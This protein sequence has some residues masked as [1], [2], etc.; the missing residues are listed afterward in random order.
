MLCCA[1]LRC[2]CTAVAT[3]LWGGLVPIAPEALILYRTGVDAQPSRFPRT[4]VALGTPPFLLLHPLTNSR[5][6][7]RVTTAAGGPFLVL[8][9][10]LP[11]LSESS[12][13]NNA[14]MTARLQRHRPRYGCLAVRRNRHIRATCSMIPLDARTDMH[15]LCFFVRR[16]NDFAAHNNFSDSALFAP[17]IMRILKNAGKMDGVTFIDQ[18]RASLPGRG[19][20][21]NHNRPFGTRALTPCFR[22]FRG[23]R[24]RI[25]QADT[26][27][28]WLGGVEEWSGGVEWPACVAF[29][30]FRVATP[31]WC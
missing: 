23:N 3:A 28:I 6:D 12:A 30:L 8:K 22:S 14:R 21:L 9:H 10:L 2:C 27:V 16:S 25:S 13:G 26:G 29:G 17:G 18:V 19:E 1:V 24:A 5:A 20:A 31:K 4:K 15:P 7:S 11:S